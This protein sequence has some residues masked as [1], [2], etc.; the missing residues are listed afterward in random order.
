MTA[1]ISGCTLRE[2]NMVISAALTAPAAIATLRQPAVSTANSLVE[3]IMV[4]PCASQSFRLNS[5][6]TNGSAILVVV[7]DNQLAKFLIAAEIDLESDSRH[8]FPNGRK[9]ADITDRLS[10]GRYDVR[11]HIRGG[12]DA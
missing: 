10:H 9:L 7:V 1:S 11:R 4:A 12:C 5:G 2:L 6:I 8:A 3:A